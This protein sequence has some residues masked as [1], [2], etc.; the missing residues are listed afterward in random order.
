[1]QHAPALADDPAY[2]ALLAASYQQ[3]GQWRESAALYQQLVAL[4]PSQG[5]WQLGLG[6]ALEQL[7]EAREA[8]QHY[9]LAQQGQGLD[10]GARRFAAE[11]A[12]ALGGQP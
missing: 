7:G 1:G 6:I 3:T 11:R 4:R 9:R 12:A 2:H 5:A 10:D 8:A